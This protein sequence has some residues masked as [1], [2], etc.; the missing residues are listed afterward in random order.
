MSILSNMSKINP[1][2]GKVDEMNMSLVARE[3]G[4]KGENEISGTN[5]V[6]K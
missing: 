4:V 2:V 1:S 6:G 3:K 5:Q